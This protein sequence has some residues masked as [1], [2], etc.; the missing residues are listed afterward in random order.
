MKIKFSE[1][2][3]WAK[4]STEDAVKWLGSQTNHPESI[5]KAYG[6]GHNSGY[7]QAI[8]DLTLHGYIETDIE[9]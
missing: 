5:L 1:Y 9:R 3:N 2:Y 6:A 7:L 8:R 4:Q